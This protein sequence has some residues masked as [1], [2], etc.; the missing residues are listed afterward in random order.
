MNDAAELPNDGSRA[1]RMMEA[2]LPNDGM[3]EIMN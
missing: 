1:C 3:M 2:E